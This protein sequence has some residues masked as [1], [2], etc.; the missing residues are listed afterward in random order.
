VSSEGSV[1]DEEDPISVE[2][3]L[4]DVPRRKKFLA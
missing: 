1:V 2:V 3:E 4:N